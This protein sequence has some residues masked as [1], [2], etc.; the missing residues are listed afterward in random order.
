MDVTTGEMTSGSWWLRNRS[1][2]IFFVGENERLYTGTKIIKG[3]Y[4]S[5]EN[6]SVGDGVRPAIYIK[7]IDGLIK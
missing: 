2:I 1:S 7:V 6:L 4:S 3:Y 5:G